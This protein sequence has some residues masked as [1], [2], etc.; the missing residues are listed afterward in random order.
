MNKCEGCC[1][2]S[3]MIAAVIVGQPL[4][5]M[6]LNENSLYYQEMANSESLAGTG[7]LAFSL[8]FRTSNKQNK[9]VL[10]PALG[11]TKHRS[12]LKTVL[13]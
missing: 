6:C 7:L 3:E 12:P 1:F 8:V 13:I 5:A 2:W 4:Q 11:V 9:P 10:M